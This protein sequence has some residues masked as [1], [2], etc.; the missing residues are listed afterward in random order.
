MNLPICGGRF[1]F[2]LSFLAHNCRSVHFV[3]NN[4]SDF[5]MRSAGSGLDFGV[6]EKLVRSKARIEHN[7][8]LQPQGIESITLDS[9]EHRHEILF[10]VQIVRSIDDV[11]APVV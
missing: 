10:L 4:E 1:I 5:W 11:D 2:P 6:R 8:D 9:I 7:E 3:R